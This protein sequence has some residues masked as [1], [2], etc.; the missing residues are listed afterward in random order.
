MSA[1][2]SAS[3]IILIGLVGGIAAF[4]LTRGRAPEIVVTS[5]MLGMSG[6]MSA[7]LLGVAFN[8]YLGGVA[9]IAAAAVGTMIVLAAYHLIGERLGS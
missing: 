6:A 1:F 9:G 5:A 2:L 3:A 4:R 8:W 7:T